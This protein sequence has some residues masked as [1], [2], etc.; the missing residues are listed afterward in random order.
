MVRSKT[1][2]LHLVLAILLANMNIEGVKTTSSNST[3]Q[4]HTSSSGAQGISSIVL[5]AATPT[6]GTAIPL[7]ETEATK[8]SYSESGFSTSRNMPQVERLVAP[9]GTTTLRLLSSISPVI[10]KRT[11]LQTAQ[12]QSTMSFINNRQITVSQGGFITAVPSKGSPILTRR[13]TPMTSV[14][15]I[16]TSDSSV[17]TKGKKKPSTTVPILT[18]A[19]LVASVVIGNS[20]V[21]MTIS[22]DKKGSAF[23]FV[24]SLAFA[25][26]FVGV[27]T[28]PV[29]MTELAS[30]PWTLSVRYCRTAHCLTWF[31]LSSSTTNLVNL[32]LDRYI[33]ISYPLHYKSIMPKKRAVGLCIVCWTIALVSATFPSIGIGSKGGNGPKMTPSLCAMKETFQPEFL[34]SFTVIFFC[35]PGVIIGIAQGRIYNLAKA[36]LTRRRSMIASQGNTNRRHYQIRN[37]IKKEAKLN[38]TFS[39]VTCAF[40][41]CWIPTISGFLLS[42]FSPSSITPEVIFPFSIVTFLNSA[43]NPFIYILSNKDMRNTARHALRSLY[44]RAAEPNKGQDRRIRMNSQNESSSKDSNQL[45]SS[46]AAITKSSQLSLQDMVKTDVKLSVK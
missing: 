25:D 37:V 27:V 1:K 20:L 19:I 5:K 26:L 13:S 12:L 38:R 30:A 28:L 14:V 31:S 3:L 9:T 43:V 45:E 18:Y 40:Y 21:L 8:P 39:F 2:I 16:R 24:T 10:Q 32:T 44:K 42:V 7:K 22:R 11:A 33:A 15:D 46:E 6:A 36:H 34:L 4:T 23:V 29:R 41:C 17:V 35:I